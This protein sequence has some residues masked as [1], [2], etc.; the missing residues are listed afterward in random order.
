MPLFA[1]SAKEARI[2]HRVLT[3]IEA[4][5]DKCP[6]TPIREGALHGNDTAFER[7]LGESGVFTR[8]GI[9]KV[10]L[11]GSVAY[12]SRTEQGKKMQEV[13]KWQIGLDDYTRG[14][15]WRK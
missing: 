14:Q 6:T 11:E 3:T 15:G 4:H 5:E 7:L 9:V 1:D 10:T 12:Y 8:N 2:R 13:L